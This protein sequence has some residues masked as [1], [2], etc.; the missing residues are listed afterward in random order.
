MMSVAQRCTSAAEASGSALGMQK[1]PRSAGQQRLWRAK[2][3]GWSRDTKW[4]K[5]G[6]T[7]I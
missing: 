4:S 1:R 5:S 7:T 3:C 6:V 2:L